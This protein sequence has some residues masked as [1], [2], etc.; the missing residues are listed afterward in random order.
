MPAQHAV[1]DHLFPP[2]TVA[3]N[4][5]LTCRSTKIGEPA[6]AAAPARFMIWSAAVPRP[7]V[8]ADTAAVAC[9]WRLQPRGRPAILGGGLAQAGVKA[10]AGRG[11]SVIRRS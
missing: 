10:L 7:P 5:E 11:A 6:A 1:G 9:A 2:C 4:V 3:R 8:A